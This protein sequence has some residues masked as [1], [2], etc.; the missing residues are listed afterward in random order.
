MDISARAISFRIGLKRAIRVASIR[1]RRE[2]RSFITSHPLAD[3][4]GEGVL[5]TVIDSSSLRAV[6][7]FVPGGRSSS[8][9]VRA[10]AP[11]KGPSTLAVALALPLALALP[12]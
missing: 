4:G 9:P 11:R 12:G 5:A 1:T 3:L 6:P 8:R 7:L 2:D 10:D